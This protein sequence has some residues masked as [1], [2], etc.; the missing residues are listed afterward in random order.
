M[1]SATMFELNIPTRVRF[2]AGARHGIAGRISASGWRRVGI[3]VDHALA[4]LP[5]VEEMT[6]AIANSCDGAFTVIC[7]IQE[8]TY[9]ALDAA[10]GPFTAQPP[11]AVIGIGGGSALDM[12]K[13]MAVLARNTGPALDYRGF[14]RMTEDVCPIIAVPTTAGTG[15][16]VTP[17]ASFIN[18]AE[19][20][21]LGIN[22]EAVR[23]KYAFLDPE[24]TLSCPPGPTVSAGVDSLVHATEAF[25]AKKSNRLARSFAAEG[26]R[27][28]FHALPELVS[29]PDDLG[30][31]EDVMYG[32]FLSGVALMHSGTGPAAALSYPLGVRHGVPHGIGGAIFLPHVI[33]ANAERGAG[34]YAELHDAVAGDRAD[35]D[36]AE[37]GRRLSGIM[38]DVWRTLSVPQDLQALGIAD[39]DIDAIV[40]DTLEIGAALEQN[41]EPFGE[42]EIRA[43]L[44]RL[45]LGAA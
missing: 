25:V 32:A 10:R 21:K 34:C 37:K 42:T 6:A 26:F 5:M 18:T 38:L 23:P 45:N 36:A 27:L 15:S 20:R 9:D 40:A 3:V 31:R 13:A 44:G 39:S 33:R 16:E 22:G 1:N 19:Q 41:P 8:P 11:D 30:L 29:R 35:V 24:L 7:D 28:V 4:A 14:D 17:N 2:G 12:A 43:V